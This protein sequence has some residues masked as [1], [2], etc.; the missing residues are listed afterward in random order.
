MVK[1]N[2]RE[3]LD[4][5]AEQF[6]ERV[7]KSPCCWVWTGPTDTH[8]TARMSIRPGLI[9]SPRTLA[10]HYVGWLVEKGT[11]PQNKREL[12]RLCDEPLCVRPS[13]WYR[14]GTHRNKPGPKPRRPK[15]EVARQ[16]P[17]ELEEA[18]YAMLTALTRELRDYMALQVEA[19]IAAEKALALS[20]QRSA[21]VVKAIGEL[22]EQLRKRPPAQDPSDQLDRIERGLAALGKVASRLSRRN[23]PE[24]APELSPP[25][26]TAPKSVASPS[27]SDR[28]GSLREILCAAFAEHTGAVID[29]QSDDGKQLEQIFDLALAECEGD[30]QRSSSTFRTWLNWYGALTA[31]GVYASTPA[32]MLAAISDEASARPPATS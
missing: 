19:R 16:A 6:Y 21:A 9:D 28:F 1:R 4:I 13:H 2:S 12:V 5:L 10:P 31:S 11:L 25:E 14:R 23:P 8:G 3:A 22:S 27:G 32:A 20:L 18:S 15:P 7:E 24:P 29:P 26:T 30:A 17:S